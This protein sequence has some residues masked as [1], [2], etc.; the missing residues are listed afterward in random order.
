MELCYIFS[1]IALL[2]SLLG[3]FG[4]V[5]GVMSYIKVEAFKNSTHQIQ[6]V[7]IDA[8]ID[9]YNEKVLSHKDLWGTSEESITI[10][11]KLYKEDLE[12]TMPEH[13]ELDKEIY[14]F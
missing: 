11:E 4:F 12:R 1:F 10:Q 3:L 9:K 2:F 5:L 13:V 8:E 14:S 6:Y 7:P